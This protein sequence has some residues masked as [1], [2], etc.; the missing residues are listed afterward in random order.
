MGNDSREL[1]A[2]LGPFPWQVSSHVQ[3]MEPV[4]H[5]WGKRLEGS[6][7]AAS[8]H[9]AGHMS[10][11]AE[12]FMAV[13]SPPGEGVSFSQTTAFALNIIYLPLGRI[14]V[15]RRQVIKLRTMQ[16]FPCRWSGECPGL[17]K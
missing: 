6:P 8:R 7:H 12:D 4:H 14:P 2:R 5:L 9:L 17:V 1:G 16:L 13:P 11:K 10:H 3:R 15:A